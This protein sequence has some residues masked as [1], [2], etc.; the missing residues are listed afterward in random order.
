MKKTYLIPLLFGVLL[1]GCNDFLGIKPKGFL[2]P[3]TEQDYEYML[4][5]HHLLKSGESY[6]AFL[7][8][9]AY[10]PYQS[11]NAYLQGFI[12]SEKYRQNAYSFQQNIFGVSEADPLWEYSYQRLYY[13]NTIINWADGVADL[14]DRGK[15]IR[16]EALTGR[17]LEYLYLVNGYGK[18]YDP[19]TSATDLAV[20]LITEALASQDAKPRAT[21]QEVYDLILKDLSL[22]VPSLPE[23][24]MLN[25]FRASKPAAYG[26]LAR[27]YLYMGNYQEAL[28][29]ANEVLK[30]NSTL[31]DYTTLKK[32][33]DRFGLNMTNVP[34][35]KNNPE[36]IYTRTAPYT[37]GNLLR[38]FPSKELEAAYDKTHDLRWIFEFD[39][40][41]QNKYKSPDFF[42]VPGWEINLGVGT[43][44]IY[45]IAA[46]CEARVGSPEKA[47]EL[48][49]KFRKNRIK[50]VQPLAT[51][52]KKEILRLVLAERRREFAE[53][54]L[55]RLIDL[56][57]LAK[58]QDNAVTFTRE[59]NGEKWTITPGDPRLVLPIPE[60]IIRKN[61][62]LVQNKRS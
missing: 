2:I 25:S 16:A 31:L 9:D 21:V 43:P 7:T 58:D 34:R 6:P 27:T 32:N 12:G 36:S 33:P 5:F 15:R 38:V 41:K 22:A 19:A 42:Y 49:N 3:E 59:L 40:S 13:Y 62:L 50:D 28:K 14:S 20:P 37:F 54:G 46:E 55:F 35:A 17:A 4:N 60:K 29:A 47:L 48:I 57:R 44:E 45:L 51:S 56:K 39:H 1:S 11:S 24:P 18:H 10:L 61:P 8:D 30:V 53:V 52:D 26:L 23:K